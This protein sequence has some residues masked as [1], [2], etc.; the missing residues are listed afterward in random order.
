ME[1]SVAVG[2]PLP[3]WLGCSTSVFL[4]ALVLYLRLAISQRD[5][6]IYMPH[7]PEVADMTVVR[8]I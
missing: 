4:H 8:E 1:F 3:S 2:L 7:V 6:N 5:I